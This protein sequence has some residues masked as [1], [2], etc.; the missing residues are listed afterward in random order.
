MLIF[1]IKKRWGLGAFGT[2]NKNGALGKLNPHRVQLHSPGDMLVNLNVT[3]KIKFPKFKLEVV[4][5]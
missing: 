1:R 4:T 5:S 3:I 2:H